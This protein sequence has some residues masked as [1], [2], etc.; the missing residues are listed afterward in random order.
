MPFA[1]ARTELANRL[2]A[3]GVPNVTLDPGATP[4]VVLVGLPERIRSTGRAGWTCELPV[5]IV[6]TPPGGP[7]AARWLLEQLPA[8]LDAAR[9]VDRCDPATL[10][11]GGKSCPA[12][13]LY[14]TVTVPNPAC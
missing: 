2:T 6:A 10:D 5:W 9:P 4:P 1:T 3:A 8:V 7:D 11:V 12:Y 13:V 14:R